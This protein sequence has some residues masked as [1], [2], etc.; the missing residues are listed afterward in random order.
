M[1]KTV[2][3]FRMDFLKMLSFTDSIDISF[4]KVLFPSPGPHPLNLPSS[5]CA[6]QMNELVGDVGIFDVFVVIPV[7]DCSGIRLV[8]QLQVTGTRFAH[9]C[10]LQL[11]IRSTTEILS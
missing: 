8:S 3:N 1:L 11:E 9:V 10:H 6:W 7:D 2:L 5:S 4:W